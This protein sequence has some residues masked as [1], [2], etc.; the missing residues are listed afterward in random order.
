MCRLGTLTNTLEN[1][2]SSQK[3]LRRGD[4]ELVCASLHWCGASSL[5]GGSQEVNVGLLM[6]GNLGEALSD[7]GRAVRRRA[8]AS[9]EGAKKTQGR[10]S[11]LGVIEGSGIVHVQT[12][13]VKGSFKV[14]KTV[15]C[16]RRQL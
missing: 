3:G 13:L 6:V 16:G 15:T 7:P 11:L 8:S 9:D 14:L 1:L 4:T 10:H 12:L 2:S 5:E